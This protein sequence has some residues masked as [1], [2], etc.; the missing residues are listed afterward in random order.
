MYE[1][2]I[3]KEKG[4]Y[5]GQHFDAQASAMQQFYLS[6]KYYSIEVGLPTEIFLS[7]MPY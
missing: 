7:L 2:E 3:I 5:N 1:T 4:N 6:V